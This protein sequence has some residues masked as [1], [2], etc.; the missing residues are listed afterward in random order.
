MF[1]PTGFITNT[2]PLYPTLLLCFPRVDIPM[3]MLIS[4]C[5]E[6]LKGFEKLLEITRLANLD[7]F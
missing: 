6:I 7:A 5:H 4:R 3:W 2:Y 1:I